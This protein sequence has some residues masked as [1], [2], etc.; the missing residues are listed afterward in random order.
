MDLM[1]DLHD[2]LIPVNVFLL[3][4]CIKFF[5]FGSVLHLSGFSNIE[6]FNLHKLIST[7]IKIWIALENWNIKINLGQLVLEHSIVLL[8]I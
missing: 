8:Y 4:I 7:L 1:N 6:K 3:G 2:S 5:A